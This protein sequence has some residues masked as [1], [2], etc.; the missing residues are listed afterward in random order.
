MS[1]KKKRK[2]SAREWL[3]RV[4]AAIAALFVVGLLG[5]GYIMVSTWEATGSSPEGARLDAVKA[6]PQWGDGKFENPLQR[7][8]G[9]Y[10]K[11][12]VDWIKGKPNT[13]PAKD[14]QIPIVPRTMA[15]FETP[16]ASGLQV[17]WLGHSTTLVEIDGHRFLLDPVWSERPSPMTWAGPRRFHPPPPPLPQNEKKVGVFW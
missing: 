2:R 16:P 17:T 15:D 4:G 12:L 11:M 13:T 10:S 9:P 5:G 3:R 8:D 1:P 14:V 6:S 7:V